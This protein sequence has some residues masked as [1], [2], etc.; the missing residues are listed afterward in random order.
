MPRAGSTGSQPSACFHCLD[1]EHAVASLS[2]PAS[3]HALTEEG[4]LSR[5]F[6]FSL[7]VDLSDAID[8]FNTVAEPDDGVDDINI[9]DDN[10][11]SMDDR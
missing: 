6:Y 3:C 1:A 9:E 2:T 10:D 11:L 4:L 5:H 7:S 8:I